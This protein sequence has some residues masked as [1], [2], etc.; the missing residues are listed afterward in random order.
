MRKLLIGIGLLTS[1]LGSTYIYT[2]ARSYYRDTSY[3]ASCNCTQPNRYVD[4]KQRYR[5]QGGS[6]C[7][8]AKRRT[9]P[10]SDRIGTYRYRKPSQSKINRYNLDISHPSRR[11]D[12]WYHRQYTKAPANMTVAE[13][14][15]L[16]RRYYGYVGTN[17]RAENTV[18]SNRHVVRYGSYKY[19]QGYPTYGY[20]N[21]GVI[22][23]TQTIDYSEY[24]KTGIP[25]SIDLQ[26][27]HVVQTGE[28]TFADRNSSLSFRITRG[29]KCAS[30]NFQQCALG[31]TRGFKQSQNLGSVQNL[32][33]RYEYNTTVE[34]DGTK[35]PTYVEGF[36]AEGYG[37]QN[38]YFVYSMLDPSDG[39]VVRI[40]AV[41]LQ[42][43]MERAS[44]TIYD[45]F[46]TFLFKP[47]QTR[48]VF[49]DHFN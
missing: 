28:N 23:G 5:S 41:G 22:A 39:S 20:Y 24:S 11:H 7:V 49:Y 27:V 29:G 3:N 9:R 46:Q 2:Q 32:Y 15:A 14:K 35:Y 18:P 1:V 36:T 19:K 12:V 42:R 48:P 6:C 16:Q 21:Q 25:Y 8:D 37:T 31:L 45:V 4:P 44:R 33:G 26:G 17:A 30:S 34:H 40:E 10:F 38:V 13:R 43:D 47:G